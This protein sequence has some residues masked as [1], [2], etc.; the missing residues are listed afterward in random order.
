MTSLLRQR[1]AIQYEWWRLAHGLMA[2]FVMLVGAA[3][4]FM[5]GHYAQPMV[6]AAAFILFA[7]APILLLT[8]IRIIRPL[9]RRAGQEWLVQ[10]VVPERPKVWTLVLR[11][12]RAE[13]EAFSFEAG[14]FAWLGFGEHPLTLQQHPFTIASS[15]RRPNELWFTI[16]ELGDFTNRIQSIQ[17]GSTVFIEGPAGAM[18]L[19]HD[20]PRLVMIAGGIGITP[21]M[22]MLRTMAD[23]GDRRPTCLIY[24]NAVLEK[25]IFR[26]ELERLKNT[27][28][29]T[30]I[31]IP[32][33]PPAGWEGPFGF[34]SDEVVAAALPA[35]ERSR[36]CVLICGP[37]KM[38]DAVERIALE[39]GMS[40]SRI[41]SERFDV[42]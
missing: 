19:P 13:A 6:K 11:P 7:L 36:T 33:V 9:R 18:V 26:D 8:F 4:I 2:V 22:A 24:G 16:K 27:L 34:I 37:A 12:A 20:V 42:V 3:H 30:V 39:L 10:R 31:H 29:L 1:L 38:M 14:Q 41:L 28:D 15:A 40:R 32:Q 23:D 17:V 35:S 21:M 5:V 25:A